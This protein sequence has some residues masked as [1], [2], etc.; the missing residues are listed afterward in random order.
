MSRRIVPG[1]FWVGVLSCSL[2]FMAGVGK[3]SPPT[4]R[5]PQLQGAWD[6]FFIAADDT[7]GGV[8]TDVAQQ[9]FRRLAGS[10]M[11]FDLESGAGFNAWNFGA[12]VT[13]ANFLTGTGV[14]PTGH[15]VFQADL[16]PFAGL[17]GNAVM[18]PEYHFVPSHGGQY[19]ISA[20]PTS[21][22]D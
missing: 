7:V 13:G 1:T 6:G 17:G 14:T 20:P 18:A 22:R 11:L 12:T 10:G 19:R 21:T 16:G 4:G 2:L 8:Q 15:L 9:D 3:A 5:V